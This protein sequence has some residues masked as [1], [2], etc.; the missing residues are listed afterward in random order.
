MQRREFLAAASASGLLAACGGSHD[1][2]NAYVQ[3]N[4]VSDSA[5]AATFRPSFGS[6]LQAP[7]FIDAWGIAIRPAGVGGHFWVAAGGYSYQFVGDVMAAADGSLRNLF[8][9]ALAIVK[10]PG[11]GVPDGEPEVSNTDKF[12]GFTTGVV[13][14]GAELTSNRF[15]VTGQTVQVD[16]ITRTLSGSAR[17]VFCTDS[18]VV[19]AWTERDAANGSIVRRNGPAVA[20]IDGSA[21]GHA[22]FGIAIK[23]GSWDTLWAADFG[24]NPQLRAWDAQWQPLALGSSFANPFL[25][26]RTTAVPGD[27]VPF[28]VQVL[29]WNGTPHVFIAYA[30]TQPDPEDA[31]QFYAAEEDAVAADAEGDRPNRG[32]VAMFDLSG[33]LVK[34]FRDDGRLNAPWGLAIAP[35]EFGRMRGALLVGNFGGAGRIAAYDIVT[36]SFIDYLRR[37]DGQR[38]EVAGLWGLQFGNGASLGDGNALYFAAGPA[39]ETQGLFGSLRAQG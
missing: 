12:V 30:K 34:A 6:T 33:R 10:I 31:T 2:P 13:F 20:V 7:E 28:N 16:G 38:V 19:S 14:N 25:E 9:D 26:G 22:Y 8:Q 3:A 32:R 18:G 15:P 1:P 11:A 23:P 29:D 27:Y 36:G 4:L 21:E 5:S 17:F 24:R 37:P 39:D 35:Q